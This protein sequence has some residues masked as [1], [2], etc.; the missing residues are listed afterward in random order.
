MAGN[1]FE[2]GFFRG[3]EGFTAFPGVFGGRYDPEVALGVTHD[4]VFRT[5]AV[6]EKGCLATGCGNHLPFLQSNRRV[7]SDPESW[8][9]VEAKVPAGQ[10]TLRTGRH[11]E[12]R[13]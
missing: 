9:I 3:L 10:E 2:F 6:H 5:G 8:E 13:V 7:T 4:P 11:Q 12:C 1:H